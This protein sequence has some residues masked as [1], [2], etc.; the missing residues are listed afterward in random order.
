MPQIP[1]FL[2]IL[3]CR[4]GDKSFESNRAMH[5]AESY[6]LDEQTL[7]LDDSIALTVRLP[8]QT[9]L[10]T[11][12]LDASWTLVANYSQTT[13]VGSGNSGTGIDSEY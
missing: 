2:A 8:P 11:E 9:G 6:E 1:A 5:G 10:S 12:V 3:E 13:N 7:S 4:R